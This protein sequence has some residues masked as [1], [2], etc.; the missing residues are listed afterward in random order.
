MMALN[1]IGA[2]AI[3]ATNQ[4]LKKDLVYRFDKAGVSAVLCTSTGACAEQ[5]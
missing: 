2:A 1:K 4:L 5:V 3:L